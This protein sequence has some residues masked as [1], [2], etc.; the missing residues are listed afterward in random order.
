MRI[1]R[2]LQGRV[3]GPQHGLGGRPLTLREQ[4]D[5]RLVPVGRAVHLPHPGLVHA[6]SE[7]G[8][9]RGEDS[10]GHGSQGG[11][12][13][14]GDLRA[15]G[16]PQALLDLGRV[17]VPS[18]HP[19][20]GHGPHGLRAQQVRL[21]GLARPRGARRGDDHEVLGRHDAGRERR[22]QREQ[23][24]R[25][26]APR[27]GDA[28]GPAQT[29]PLRAP[30]RIHDQ[31]GQT[32]RPRAR[33]LRAVERL[34]RLGGREPVVRTGVHHHGL[35]GQ[36]RGHRGGLAVRQGQEH[37]VVP[38][39]VL[40]GGLQDLPVRELV[41]VRLQLPQAASGRGVGGDGGDLDLRVPAQQAEHLSARVA[42]GARDCCG[43][44]HAISIAYFYALYSILIH[45]G[46]SDHPPLRRG[47][48]VHGGG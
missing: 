22:C 48:P 16:P 10:P 2:E 42:G 37:D 25:G 29:V 33:V 47:C 20:G 27:H 34:P 12:E 18:A 7:H 28:C 39:E 5:E 31:L 36:L 9:G 26:V 43:V 19:V 14:Q 45:Q 11:S 1:H 17:P 35:R 40:R 8:G 4:V 13:G 41:Q 38:R 3:V 46:L 15:P 32:V 30:A 24:T 23:R 21:G 6:G 44:G